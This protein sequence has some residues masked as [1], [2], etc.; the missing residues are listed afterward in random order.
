MLFCINNNP[1]NRR[2][3]HS[4]YYYIIVLERRDIMKKIL[5]HN[6]GILIMILFIINNIALVNLHIQG[7]LYIFIMAL[8]ILLNIL[9]IIKYKKEIKY[10]S[11]IIISFL[12][13][14]FSK[15][16]YN[17]VFYITNII[18]FIVVGISESKINQITIIIVG[19]IFVHF[20][21]FILLYI[22]IVILGLNDNSSIYEEMHYHC[23]NNYNVYAYSGGAM[24]SFH[25]NISKDYEILNID[26]IITIIY[27]KR[28]EKSYE[29]YNNFINNHNCKLVGEI[30]EFK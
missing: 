22:F 10:K 14:L 23:D 11:L 19:A 2:V 17:L 4:D 6:Y 26:G 3:T 24:D 28:N 5:I 30:H 8:I 16:V 13:M 25:Y 12:L 1:T 9:I 21:P 18:T 15:D 29:E 7:I 27:D 20:H